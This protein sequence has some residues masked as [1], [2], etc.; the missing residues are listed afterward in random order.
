MITVKFR[1][2]PLDGLEEQMQKVTYVDVP[3]PGKAIWHGDRIPLPKEARIDR[4]RYCVR[5]MPDGSFEARG[6]PK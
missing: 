6:E 1:G 5:Q 4:Y 2:G 3:L